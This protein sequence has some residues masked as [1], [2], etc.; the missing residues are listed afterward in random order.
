[1]SELEFAFFSGPI[2]DPIPAGEAFAVY[3]RA[4]AS[5]A[6]LEHHMDA[7]IIQINKREHST[8][9]YSEHPETFGRKIE[10]MKRWFNQYPPLADFQIDIRELTSRL[11]VLSRDHRNMYLHS[12]FKSYDPATLTVEL[13]NIKMLPNGDIRVRVR[14]ITLDQLNIFTDLVNAS[15]RYLGTV[16]LRLFTPDGVLR[17]RRP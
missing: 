2:D 9:L 10:V 14:S 17:L 1:M 6:R 7:V 12:I 13:Q 15:N 5:W 11:K 8:E 16:S 3:G 4:A